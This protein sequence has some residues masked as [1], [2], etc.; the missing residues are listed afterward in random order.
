MK[1]IYLVDGNSFV[2]RAF[3]AT[4]YLSNSKGMPT[5]A[6]YAFI[7]MLKKL[8][9]ERKPEGLVVVWDSRVPSF[10]V[11]ISAEYK[12]TRPPMPGNLSLQFPYVKAIVDAM[13]IPTLEK[14]GF[15]A[16][17]IIATLVR[18]LEKEDARVIVVTSDKDIMQ[19]ACD[20]VTIFD[21]MKNMDMGREEVA[22]KF[23]IDPCL[24]PDFLALAGDTSDNIPGV[25]GIGEKTA[26]DLISTFGALEDIYA[27]VDEVKKP[28]VRQKLLDNRDR[29]EMSKQLATLHV[30]VPLDIRLEGMVVSD[31][32]LVELRR[33]YRDLEFTSLYRE[34]K[35]EEEA[36]GHEEVATS[37]ELSR[38]A[39][40]VV[41]SIQG[42]C[43]YD[44]VLDRFALSD[45]NKVFYSEKMDELFGALSRARN[46][47]VHN[48]K[49]LYLAAV[50]HDVD[51]TCALFDTML[52]V[53]LI[54]PARK[55]Y[56]IQSI[57]SELLGVDMNGDDQRE[58]LVRS[59]FHLPRLK[60]ELLRRLDEMGLRDLFYDIE[61]P[62]VEVLARMEC[63]G[64]RVDRKALLDLSRDFDGRLNKI[65]AHIY[66]L[67]GETFNINSPQQLVR[68]LFHR[69]NLP[70]IKKTKTSLSTDNEVLQTLSDLH[71]L[72]REILE[73]RMLTKLKSTYVD[74]LQTLIHQATGRIHASFNQMVVATGRLS[75]SD[76]NLQNIPIKGI[77]GKKIREAFIPED[78][79]LFV[80][81][82]YSQIEL[83]VLAHISEDELL[84]E[85]FR[86]DE[87]I[88]NRVA[89]EVFRVDPDNVTPAMRRTAKVIN[90]GIVYGISGFGLA[91]EL[92]VGPKEAQ[93]YI[94]A[95]FERHTGIRAY[96]ERT[97]AEAREKGFVRTLFGRIRYIPELSNSDTN[98]RQFGERTAM[99]TPIQGT[100]ADII[101]MAMVNI[102]RKMRERGYRSRLILQIH[103]ELVFEIPEAEMEEMETLIRQ[104]MEHVCD[105]QVPLKVSIGRGK[106]WAEAH[107]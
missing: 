70:V 105:L 38:E 14:E 11:Q 36:S 98:V 90:F 39:V 17:D 32:D 69:F 78:G 61:M 13:G 83:R 18:R 75:S 60:E 27:H 43:P 3:F 46:A 99:N 45:G 65:I 4:P 50:K 79:F 19:L 7:N 42:R 81:S 52:A 26:R 94:D 57:L 62:L 56:S 102:Y 49:P 103:D 67:A 16:D 76:P 29:A 107:D 55:E 48:L 22:E 5:N 104:E 68:I 92:G 53:Y 93:A 80:S 89:S 59:A 21:S 85:A 84:V 74:S 91:K 96:I 101:K 77:E 63:L 8:I 41:A 54:N 58:A 71:P 24:I 40:G 25:P 31:P 33:I 51:L 30:D 10:R 73:Y 95:Y 37:D 35:V 86:N 97:V 28:S 2:Y 66:E 100:A 34:I 12:A 88:H 64:V 6:I 72:P 47:A 23:G 15:E 82:D 87:D 44:V 9:S 20:S 106:N 1:Q